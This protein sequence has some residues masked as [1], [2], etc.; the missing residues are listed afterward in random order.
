MTPLSLDEID[1]ASTRSAAT[2]A[3]SGCTW[4]PVSGMPDGAMIALGS[5][6]FAIRGAQRSCRGRPRAMVEPKPRPGGEVQVLTPPL[7]SRRST[8]ATRR[9]G[10]RARPVLTARASTGIRSVAETGHSARAGLSRLS[11]AGRG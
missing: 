1:A 3:R 4:R 7:R 6:A 2:A 8:A 5:D 11:R 9:Y 10:I